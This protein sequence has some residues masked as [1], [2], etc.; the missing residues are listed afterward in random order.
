MKG[1]L[2]AISAEINPLAIRNS[3]DIAARALAT[4]VFLRVYAYFHRCEFFS[5][6][7]LSPRQIKQLKRHGFSVE[8]RD[9]SIELP[10]RKAVEYLATIDG[11]EQRLVEI[12]LDTIARP[13]D[14]LNPWTAIGMCICQPQSGKRELNSFTGKS[15]KPEHEWSKGCMGASPTL[16]TG[17]RKKDENG[18]YIDRGRY[19]HIA[20]Y[21]DLLCHATNEDNCIHVEWRYSGSKF[22]RSIGISSPA[23]LLAFDFEAYWRE[24]MPFS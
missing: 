9:I 12:A 8:G 6:R 19:H 21:A 24:H 11:V 4:Y 23:D 17:G 1:I 16:Y 20:A 2:P 10:P 14:C 15:T 22:L 13:D 5:S 3:W 18:R 7:A